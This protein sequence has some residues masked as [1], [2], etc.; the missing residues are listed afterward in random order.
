MRRLKI[1]VCGLREPQNIAEVAALKPD[2]VGFVFARDSKRWIGK[3]FDPV[4]LNLLQP[5]T[6]ACGV[7]MGEYLPTLLD[8]VDYYH[9]DAIQLH[10]DEPAEYCKKLRHRAPSV[11]IIKAFGIDAQ[12]NFNSL[13][14]YQSYVDFFLFDA[15][16]QE[17]GGN[18]AA[19]DWS[20]LRNY[21]GTLPYFLSGGI[22]PDSVAAVKALESSADKLVGVDVNSRFE[23]APALKSV[24]ELAKF[25][26]ALQ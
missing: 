14:A 22:G 6:K 26:S 12:F 4:H 10:G 5:E 18:G 3:D 11:E 23:T 9:L 8:R 20:L 1:K 17:R 2:Y 7:F 19:F 13:A 15:K 25:F 21:A 24:S 16:G